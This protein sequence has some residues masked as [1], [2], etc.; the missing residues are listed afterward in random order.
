MAK[1]INP[2]PKRTGDSA[3]K[4]TRTYSEE[5]TRAWQ[6]ITD[7]TTTPPPKK[8]NDSKK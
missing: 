2:T 6:P 8:E 7:R 3:K 5:S 1:K 4:G